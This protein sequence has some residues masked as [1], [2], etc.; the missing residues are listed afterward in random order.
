[1]NSIANLPQKETSRAANKQVPSFPVPCSLF[2]N[3]CLYKPLQLTSIHA[4]L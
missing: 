3:P 1:M 2:P 4:N